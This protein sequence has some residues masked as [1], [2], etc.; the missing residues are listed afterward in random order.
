[1]IL[2]VISKTPTSE[3]L[4]LLMTGTGDLANRTPNDRLMLILDW[5]FILEFIL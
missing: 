1:M 3:N 5:C 4:K 2:M